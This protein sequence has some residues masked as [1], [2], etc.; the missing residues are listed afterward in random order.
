MNVT[1]FYRYTYT[2]PNHNNSIQTARLSFEN[3]FFFLCFTL[4][5]CT[6]TFFSHFLFDFLFPFPSGAHPGQGFHWGRKSWC[7]GDPHRRNPW[8]KCH[9]FV[10]SLSLTGFPR[11]DW[12]PRPPWCRRASGKKQISPCNWFPLVQLELLVQ[13]LVQGRQSLFRWL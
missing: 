12:P 3:P 1:D 9:L 5:K 4:Y 6:K 10:F 11:Q 8:Q 13:L 2:R 7:Q